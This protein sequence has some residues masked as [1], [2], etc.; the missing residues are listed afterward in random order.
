M[1]ERL[2][3]FDAYLSEY[4]KMRASQN[5]EDRTNDPWPWHPASPNIPQQSTTAA[6]DLDLLLA[7]LQMN[8]VPPVTAL[9]RDLGA[10]DIGP[11][12]KEE[13]LKYL[14]GN[15]ATM[16]PGDAGEIPNSLTK[17]GNGMLRDRSLGPAN[18]K[19]NEKN[20]YGKRGR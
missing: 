10:R 19:V 13:V 20:G 4:D 2:G 5:I 14:M 18:V 16:Q 3:P 1:V 6:H 15:T 11:L 12:S 7:H 8:D 9:S 17:P